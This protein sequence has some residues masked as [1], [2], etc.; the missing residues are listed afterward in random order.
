MDHSG[1]PTAQEAFK[2]LEVLLFT[3]KMEK[4]QLQKTSQSS[5]ASLTT[6]SKKLTTKLRYGKVPNVE[7]TVLNS[8]QSMDHLSSCLKSLTVLKELKFINLELT[9][10]EKDSD[11]L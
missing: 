10:R 4:H 7:L 1:F 2:L 11:Q 8:T 9:S 5:D 3:S 6:L